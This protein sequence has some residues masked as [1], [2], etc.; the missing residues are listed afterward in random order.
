MFLAEDKHARVLVLVFLMIDVGVACLHS[1]MANV[2]SPFNVLLSK[3]GT[4]EVCILAVPKQRR[5]ERDLT[6]GGKCLVHPPKHDNRGPIFSMKKD[7][8]S[9]LVVLDDEVP[10]GTVRFSSPL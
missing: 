9:R 6:G 2:D 5:H 1:D 3:C 10:N 8:I 7:Y 4:Y